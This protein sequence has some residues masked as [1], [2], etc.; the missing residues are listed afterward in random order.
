ML[1]HGDVLALLLPCQ[2]V[3]VRPHRMEG[4]EGH[5]CTVQ[6]QRPQES[7]EMAGLVVLDID[8]EV[9]QETPAVLSDAEKMNPGAIGAAGSTGRL[10]IHG[11]GP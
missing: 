2:P 5:H 1:D 10:A 9:V 4:V 7:G 11:H 6:V 8:L 3:Q